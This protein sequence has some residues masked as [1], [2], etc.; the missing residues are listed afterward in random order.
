VKSVIPAQLSGDY[1]LSFKS[2]D[3]VTLFGHGGTMGKEKLLHFVCA[4]AAQV[5][6]F[7]TSALL[8]TW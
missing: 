7:L 3:L 4:I 2:D 1:F 6:Y 5:L 8:Y